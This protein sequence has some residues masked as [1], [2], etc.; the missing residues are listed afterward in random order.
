[1]GRFVCTEC[2]EFKEYYAHTMCRKCYQK[3]DTYKKRRRKRYH[4]I[5]GYH[6][7]V[8]EESN[9]TIKNR[10]KLDGKSYYAHTCKDLEL[11]P[12][13]DEYI[14]IRNMKKAMKI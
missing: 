5:E 7:K 13:L 2:K 14:N 11:K 12:L 3:S 8:L 9:N 10:M 1:M 4:D 6:D